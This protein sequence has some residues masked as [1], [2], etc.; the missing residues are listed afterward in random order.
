MAQRSTIH[1]S[2]GFAP[3]GLALAEQRLAYLTELYDS[4]RWRRFHADA[5][6][7]SMVRDTKTAVDTW[8]R[9]LRL[10]PL[11]LQDATAPLEAALSLAEQSVRNPPPESFRQVPIEM[12]PVVDGHDDIL[13]SEEILVHED[14][15]AHEGILEREEGWESDAFVH[16]EVSEHEQALEPQVFEHRILEHDQDLKHDQDL[17]LLRILSQEHVLEREE[18]VTLRE[19]IHARED[20]APLAPSLRLPPIVFSPHGVLPESDLAEA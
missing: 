8:R 17:E 13:E 1:F 11:D 14:V 10:E 20:V 19:P 16:E 18:D 2:D 5:E 7:L 6:F 3:R 9:I 12:A 4:G 15:R